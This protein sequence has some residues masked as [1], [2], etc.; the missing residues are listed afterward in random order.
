MNEQNL[1]FTTDQK[2][3]LEEMNKIKSLRN[4]KVLIPY[5]EYIL[6]EAHNQSVMM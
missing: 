1:I 4:E 2:S 3:L 5:Q 6:F